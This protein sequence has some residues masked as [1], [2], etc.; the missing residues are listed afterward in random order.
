MNRSTHAIAKTLAAAIATAIIAGCGTRHGKAA[1]DLPFA[2]CLKNK[3]FKMYGSYQCPHCQEQK[4]MFSQAAWR[5][6]NYVECGPMRFPSPT[7]SAAHIRKYPTW[8]F[9]G[10]R[11]TAGVLTL[12][13]L[14][15]QSGCR[16]Q[17]QP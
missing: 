10:G 4:D 17:K 14:A 1:N 7:C 15:E 8:E 9:P 6:M 3:G 11:R 5:Q 16:M 12:E 13:K 2:L